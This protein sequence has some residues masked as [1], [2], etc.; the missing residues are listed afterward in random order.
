MNQLGGTVTG[1][2]LADAGGRPMRS[3]TQAEAVPGQ[4]L[5]GD[6]YQ[7]GLG[8]WSY[9]ARLCNDVTLIATEVLAAIVAEG[10]PELRDGLHRRNVETAGI[11]LMSLVGRRF[12]VGAVELRGDRACDPCRYLDGVVGV[13]AMAALRDRGG[14]RATV[15]G[16]GVLRVGD[17]VNCD[18]NRGGSV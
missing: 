13:S 4:G 16:A 8:E 15:L 7:S 12:R 17:P 9:D 6:R 10:G 2:F 11:D 3:V 18:Q 14:L 5:L 1:V